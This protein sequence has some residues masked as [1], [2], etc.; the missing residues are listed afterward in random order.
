V[1]NNNHKETKSF[2]AEVKQVLDLMIHSLYSNKEIFL[3]ELIANAADAADKL[4]FEALSDDALF[5][6]DADLQVWVEADKEKR[7]VT[8]RDNGIGMNRDEVMENIG[9]IA[10]SGTRQF[11]DKMT[12]D[13]AEDSNLIG[14]FGVGFYSSFIVADKVTLNTRRA[15]AK[16]SEGVRWE[17]SGDGAYDI[18]DIERTARGTEVILHLREDESEFLDD[19]RLKSIVHKYSEH[20]PVPVRML[21]T[22]PITESDEED[23][24]KEDGGEEK[25]PETI[26]ETINQAAALWTRSP[27]DISDEEYESFYKSVSHDYEAPMARMH[28]RLEGKFE[29]T[30]ML[31]IPN[32]APYDLWYQ[33]SKHGVK[34]YVRRVFIMDVNEDLLPR[35]M[36][37]MR[38]VIDT[39][40]L[41][42]NVSR[43][44]LQ[45]HPAMDAIKKGAVKRVLGMIEDIAKDEEQYQKFYNEFGNALKEGVIEDSANG[46]RLAKLLRFHSTT[47]STGDATVSL[48]AYVER[49]REGQD[50]IYYITADSLAAAK[51]S[52]HLEVFA[53][54]DVEVLLLHDRIDEWLGSHLTEFDGKSF[55][56]ISKGKL[57]LSGL[58]GEDKKDDEDKEEDAN[59]SMLEKLSKFLESKVQ[60]VRET[61]RLTESPSCLVSDEFAMSTNMER[62]LKEAGQQTPGMKPIL[63]INPDHALVK[64]L[65]E[66]DEQLEQWAN[67][68]FDQAVLSEG[69]QLQDPSAFVRRMNN[70]LLQSSN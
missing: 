32:R 64:A 22:A 13:K 33:E 12:G 47:A 40:D 7:T 69:G 23:N 43:E 30:L 68:L 46:D 70:M 24:D 53:K 11:V 58:D 61:D 36:R 15:G 29:Y 2:Q 21:G 44:I 48:K 16:A 6:G 54:K 38:G 10:K 49:M 41:P 1:S 25:A 42:L 27:S 67:L 59:K 34:L 18:S 60:E 3:R 20:T 57:D 9:T 8:I 51:N 17:S 56:S 4:R 62:I 14:Q 28:K 19:H 26:I 50:K 66:D 37:F 35:Y 63:E 5:E 45:R 55:Q 52:P 31:F 39:S 65:N